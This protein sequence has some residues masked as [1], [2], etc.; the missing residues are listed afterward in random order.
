VLLPDEIA[1]TNSNSDLIG[2]LKLGEYKNWGAGIGLQWDPSAQVLQRTEISVQ[3][4]PTAGRVINAAYVYRKAAVSQTT[5]TAPSDLK[6][7]DTS[8]AW[9]FGTH[10]NLF[11]RY[12]YS[13]A[14]YKVVDSLAGVE[15][16][17]CCWGFRFG[18]H[19]TRNQQGELENAWQW[20]V[21]LNGLADVGSA[22]DAFLSHA[23]RGYSAARF[24]HRSVP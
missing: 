7:I 4:S 20:Q 13:L 3:Y 22:N 24:D 10:V 16:R 15:Y 23:I 2:E 6:Q 5:P 12:V 9:P 19:Q 11:A 1:T 14:D 8:V 17:D 21:E 18:M